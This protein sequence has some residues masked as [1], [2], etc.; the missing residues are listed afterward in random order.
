MGTVPSAPI[1][2]GITVTLMFLVLEQSL[3]IC[4]FSTFFDFHLKSTI[5]QVLSSFSFCK[6]IARCGLLAVIIRSVCISQSLRILYLSCSR[7]D[8]G[9]SMKPF[10]NKV[11]FQFFA[12][13]SVDHLPHWI[14]SS[15]FLHKNVTFA[16]YVCNRFVFLPILT[17]LDI[18]LRIIDFGFNT[19]GPY[20]VLCCY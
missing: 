13:F 2:N 20:G 14:V 6:I 19:I 3:S 11:K 7:K 15:L 16:Y 1:T 5:Q 17:S 12:Q 4:L 10:G 9:L 18:L 8:S